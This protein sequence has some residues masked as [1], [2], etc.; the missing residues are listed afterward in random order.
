LIAGLILAGGQS[1]RFGSDKSGAELGG[2][3][4]CDWVAGRAMPLVDKLFLNAPK[5]THKEIC[6]S[7]PLIPDDA[8]GYLGP[9]AGVLAGLRWLEAH[10]GGFNWLATFPVD[11]PFFPTDLVS[12]L[13]AAAK[14]GGAPAVA[15]SGGRLHPVFTLWPSA[16]V[17]ELEAYMNARGGRKM[18]TFLDKVDAVPVSFDS[19]PFDPFFNIN[20]ADDLEKAAVIAERYFVS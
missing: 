19:H 14:P 17:P 1:R 2:R 6:A 8:E 15:E 7:L 9:L 3:A 10:E 11:S 16:V 5:N 12:R 18:M 4:L 13:S 20:T